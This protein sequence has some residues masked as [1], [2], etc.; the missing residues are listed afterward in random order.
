MKMSENPISP[1]IVSPQ[2]VAKPLRPSEL[3]HDVDASDILLRLYIRKRIEGQLDFYEKR[4]KEF[5]TNSGF[6][7]GVG[8]FIMAVSTVVSTIGATQNS[9]VLALIT[10]LLPALAALSASMRQ[11]YQ[12]DKQASLYRDAALGLQEARLLVP[13]MDMYEREDSPVILP[14]MIRTAEDVF[15]AEINQWG[16]IALGL[17]ESAQAELAASIEEARQNRPGTPAPATSSGGGGSRPAAGSGS[18]NLP[19]PPPADFQ[20]GGVG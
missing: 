7:V 8:A 18:Q 11:L 20:D 1:R 14:Q 12:W 10:A 9:P 6:M 2:G 17:D 13:D 15:T 3:P 4:I 5:E 16:Q 19:P